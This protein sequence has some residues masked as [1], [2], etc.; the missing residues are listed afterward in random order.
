MKSSRLTLSIGVA[1]L[2]GA[3]FAVTLL[4]GGFLRFAYRSAPAFGT[5]QSAGQI[6]G[7]V[8]LVALILVSLLIAVNSALQP[9]PNLL[10]KIPNALPAWFAG[11][12][13]V[14]ALLIASNIGTVGNFINVWIGAGAVLTAVS[15]TIAAWRTPLGPKARRAATI[16][17]LVTGGLGVLAAL[18]TVVAAV[19][20]QCRYYPRLTQGY[21]PEIDPPPTLA[22]GRIA[23]GI[24]VVI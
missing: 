14:G 21:Y 10:A 8:A 9:A 15:V 6:V 18:A 1:I 5:A 11:F 20:A 4:V 2:F 12:T 23:N 7:A 13:I 24:V 16:G 17:L 19:I 3:A 22:E